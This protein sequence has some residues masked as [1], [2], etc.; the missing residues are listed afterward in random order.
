MILIMLLIFF[1]GAVYPTGS[2]LVWLIKYRKS[3]PLKEFWKD[4]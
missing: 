1:M 4:I 3:I 2:F